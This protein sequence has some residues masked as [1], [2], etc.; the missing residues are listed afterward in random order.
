MDDVHP[1]LS[2]DVESHNPP[3]RRRPV[4]LFNHLVESPGHITGITRYA[5]GLMEAIIRRGDT[6]L[7]LATAWTR[8]QLPAV[9]AAGAEAV[10]TLPH[11]QS[12]PLN[13]LRQRLKLGRI[14]RTYNVNV[15]YGT[16]PLCPPV[17]GI[18][19]IITV[20]DLYYEVLPE[21][22]T[23]RHRLWWKLFFSDAAR[24]AAM[25]AA[26]SAST[27][28][29][30]VRLHPALRGKTRIVSGA[31]VLPRGGAAPPDARP[32]PPYVLLLGNAAR[33]KNIGF[34]VDALRLLASQGRPVRALHVG[35]DLTGDLAKALSGD[36]AELL[37]S[38]GS[39]DDPALD[40]L[41]RDAAA[42]VQPSRYEGFGLPVVEAQQRG[43][44]VVASDIAIFREVA[45]DGGML[46]ELG[47]VPRLAEAMHAITTDA[48]LRAELSAK[49]LINSRRFTWH[50]S[51]EA[52]VS[53]I[54]EV[55]VPRDRCNTPS[56]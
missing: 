17:R 12:T 51:A 46:V 39:V 41:L 49:A 31:G 34:A 54:I 8:D 47:N 21:L 15:V 36:G 27:A 6:R 20:H 7:I 52:A 48:S 30:I 18:P 10:I 11:I 13:N 56:D 44:P 29:D 50:K 23:R 40:A 55:V 43:V 5:F 42:L 38:L 28:N 45:G 35:R 37:R 32:A 2:T 33:T 4:V 25:I 14:A 22:Y 1:E 9:I 26:V 53:M 19:S 3:S 16:S 24:R